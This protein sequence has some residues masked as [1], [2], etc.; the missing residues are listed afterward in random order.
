MARR[1]G[2]RARTFK[3][4][5]PDWG[6]RLDA[7]NIVVDLETDAEAAIRYGNGH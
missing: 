6:L 4:R 1:L 5:Y 3:H 2:P 7:R